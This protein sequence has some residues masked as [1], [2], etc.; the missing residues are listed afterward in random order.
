MTIAPSSV[1]Y[2]GIV[3]GLSGAPTIA[4]VHDPAG[5]LFALTVLGTADVATTYLGT[6]TLTTTQL[7]DFVTKA[8]ANQLYANVHT[9]AVPDGEARADL[10]RIFIA[11]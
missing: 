4:H 3:E 1:H 9:A 8:E 11:P 2:F 7:T 5:A 10:T 6:P